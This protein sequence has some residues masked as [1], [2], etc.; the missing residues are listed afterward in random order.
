MAGG[1]GLEYRGTD[2]FL[3]KKQERESERGDL[4]GLA[5]EIHS[6]YKPKKYMF[7]YT[8]SQLSLF[9]FW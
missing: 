3:A 5:F 2:G 7:M 9:I 4:L 8:I 6:I 1:E